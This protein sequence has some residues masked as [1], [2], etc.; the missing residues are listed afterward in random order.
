MKS[1]PQFSVFTSQYIKPYSTVA[2][3][4]LLALVVLKGVEWFLLG[5]EAPNW[6]QILVN[7]VVYNLV[8]ASWTVLAVGLLY[9][10]VCLLSRRVALVLAALCYGLLL[11]AETGLLLY[12]MHNGYLLG[13][14][15][16]VRPLSEILQAIRGSVGVFLPLLLAVGLTGGFAALALWR[17]SH[18]SKASYAT[19]PAVVVFVLLSLVFKMSHLVPSAYSHYILNKTHYVVV[20]S[21]D[22][23]RLMRSQE[24]R[25]DDAVP[26]YDE[27]F[28]R[29]L[30][31]THPEWG[32]PLDFQYPLERPFTPDTFLN[33]YF[34]KN[35]ATP[36][37][38]VVILVESLGAE[39]MGSG[40]MPFVDSLA[41]TGLYWP[42]CLS[43]TIRSYG[44]LPAIT[45][46]VG[47]PRSFQF[48]TM[49]AHNTLLSI[50]KHDGYT[51]RAYYAG[52]FSF[53]CL[54]EYLTAQH[55]DG[56][57]P[58]YDEYIASGGYTHGYW[59]GYNDDYLFRRTLEDLPPADAAHPF[60]AVVTTLTMH[61]DLKLDDPARQASYEQRAKRLPASNE[62]RF[63][64]ACLFTDDALRDFFRQYRR[65]PDFRNTLFVITGDHASGYQKGDKLSYHHVPLILW[66]P[67]V[68]RPAVFRHPVTHNDIAP[69][70]ASLLSQRY[71][72]AMPATVHWLG[73]G[74]GPSPKT[75]L[76]V[77]YAHEI[78]DL[79][80][81]NC[82]YRR[83]TRF[84]PEALCTFGD[85]L[86]LHDS[87]D[88]VLLDSCRR[89]MELMRWLYNYT[90]LADRLTAHPLYVRH[91]RTD[92][93]F[94]LPHIIAYRS[95]DCLPSLLG[96]V[97]A[98]LLPSTPLQPSTG[99]TMV[100]I[101]MESDV[102]VTDSLLQH[103]FPDLVFTLIGDT[104][105]CC[106]DK[107]SK[108][109]LNYSDGL[110]GTY[111]ISLVKEFPL[112][113]ADSI[114]VSLRSPSSDSDFR[115]DSRIAL[116]NTVFSID[117]GK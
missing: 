84:E 106:Y 90:Y 108:F 25:S 44:A 117:Y 45:G 32:T 75:L 99:E 36:S 33:A 89:Q 50:L 22:Y 52:D 35:L 94:T 12:L 8:V 56:F 68:E 111:H 83:G 103:H 96:V 55:I 46:S 115:P 64:P 6:G 79:V 81:R 114:Q 95:P 74:L 47:G 80:Y 13:C 39:F 2:G 14:E 101:G 86:L 60:C 28:V 66:S 113:S 5:I 24:M 48:G 102:T 30:L 104:V 57:S 15:L 31:S 100:R 69:A 62:D 7:A 71:G 20:D 49:P 107:L 87:S 40:A 112:T 54:Y 109:L 88:P 41:A 93:V 43:T 98:P 3:I 58:Y 116:S 85:D 1:N 42:N 38:V 10:L 91:Y 29:E 9:G 51:T 59:W 78:S 19:L 18:P 23:L 67:L 72:V 37:N 110:P 34:N 16:V 76:V 63:Y 77:N 73:D 21:I 17:A 97:S 82:Y 70:V 53:D 92:R 11:M 4:Y 65:R 26:G 61:D 27:T 105:L